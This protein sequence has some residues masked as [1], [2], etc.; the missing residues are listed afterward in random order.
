MIG[1]FLRLFLNQLLLLPIVDHA[2]HW[3]HQW[4]TMGRL[5]SF[6]TSCTS[7]R[8]RAREDR[9]Q[10]RAHWRKCAC[11]RASRL[12]LPSRAR[13]ARDRDL[14]RI[15]DSAGMRVYGVYRASRTPRFL[16]IDSTS[17]NGGFFFIEASTGRLTFR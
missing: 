8:A 1:R 13:G 12:C 10:S 16:Q 9:V 6:A 11:V 5:L 4:S 17:D 3:F 15:R 2:L 7:E 14:A